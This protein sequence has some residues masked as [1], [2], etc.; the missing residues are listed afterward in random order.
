MRVAGLLRHN[1]LTSNL[2]IFFI[3]V[4]GW[5]RVD[6]VS[7]GLQSSQQSSLSSRVRLAELDLLAQKKQNIALERGNFFLQLS[8]KYKYITDFL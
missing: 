1:I 8:L 6:S 5:R 3:P 2:Y 7:L 4:R